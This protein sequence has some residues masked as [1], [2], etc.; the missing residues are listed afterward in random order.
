[1]ADEAQVA[2][3]RRLI[4]EPDNV[5]PWMDDVLSARLDAREGTSIASLAATIWREKAAMYSGLIDVQ[6]GSSSRKL[7]QLQSQA[8]KMADS[9]ALADGPVVPTK[10]PATTRRIER[11]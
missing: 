10:R 6:E 7:S 9:L 11:Q 3:L 4:D 5:P 1:M 8:L 2:E